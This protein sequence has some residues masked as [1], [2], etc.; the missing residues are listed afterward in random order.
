MPKLRIKEIRVRNFGSFIEESLEMGD[1][2]YPVLVLGDNGAGKT[3]FFVDSVTYAFF[4]DAYGSGN[5]SK[6][7]VSRMHSGGD[8]EATVVLESSDGVVFEVRNKK[9]YRV[10][11]RTEY[12]SIGSL[13]GHDY[14]TLLATY[15]VRQGGVANFF[16]IRAAE[17]RKYLLD[18]LNYRFDK[19]RERVKKSLENI[20]D[21]ISG[22]ENELSRIEGMFKSQGLEEVSKDA[23]EQVL[24]KERIRK[25]DL[26]SRRESLKKELEDLI[27]RRETL[28]IRKKEL[29]NQL[30]TIKEYKKAL[31]KL[32]NVKTKISKYYLEPDKL[33][34]E[35]VDKLKSYVEKAIEIIERIDSLS[36]SKW[37]IERYLEN[38]NKI[39][40]KGDAEAIPTLKDRL[41][42][43]REERGRLISENNMYKERIDMLSKAGS[44]CPVCGSPLDD[45]HRNMVLEEAQNKIK[46]L[47]NRMKEVNREIN[48]LE[49]EV[50]RLENLKSIVVKIIGG[51]NEVLKRVSRDLG[52]EIAVVDEEN[53]ISI[54]NQFMDK[55]R[56]EL[57][58]LNSEYDGIFDN[59][60]DL[61]FVVS[62]L[63]SKVEGRPFTTARKVLNDYVDWV[64]RLYREF[65][66]SLEVVRNYEGKVKGLKEDDVKRTLT[67]LDNEIKDI[68]ERS[69]KVRSE[70]ERV[71]SSLGEVDARIKALEGLKS[72][73]KSYEEY[74]K[75][76]RELE[77]ER[78]LHDDLIKLFNEGG[79]PTYL[80]NEV[81][82]PRLN[83]YTN[84]YLE[85]FNTNFKVRFEVKGTTIDAKVYEGVRERVLNSLSGG[86][87][88]LIGIAFRL[89]F[90][91]LI[92]MLGMNYVFDFI[93]L[94]E[95]LTHL[96][97]RNKR[98]VAEKLARMV[99]EG[100]ISQVIIITHDRT[101]QELPFMNGSV[102]RVEK[103]ASISRVD[104]VNREEVEI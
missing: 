60:E 31:E 30:N 65:R 97:D 45:I 69:R 102:V 40:E 99:E 12:P 13:T 24:E 103:T 59:I 53:V 28:K 15:I 25:R 76:L 22:V 80:I 8:V 98:I 100:V 18:L 37:D 33:Q 96:D 11:P 49:R 5:I 77:D 54:S 20:K 78:G 81:I 86:E 10:R 85:E 34:E 58:R 6:K 94:D 52:M 91:R 51:I 35:L 3:V 19:V 72:Y 47:E 70:V 89:A 38:Y 84:Y 57:E 64:E 16:E 82:I 73:L 43:L 67:E 26:E 27:N 101:I 39:I 83:E 55:I 29:E 1:L 50:R 56:D 9:V 71:N 62:T 87:M 48:E 93:I 7:D 21:E 36:D 17:R 95:A 90:G 92:A 32:D 23:L 68:E 75:R 79:F 63:K 41:N 61:G 42:S 88:T 104:V 14:R 44:T 74:R 46:E 66:G 2:K 4:G